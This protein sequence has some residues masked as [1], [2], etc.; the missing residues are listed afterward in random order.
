MIN[1]K[2][3]TF[4]PMQLTVKPKHTFKLKMEGR[5]LI[6]QK[7]MEENNK[8]LPKEDDKGK[9]E[10]EKE[11]EEENW[12]EKEDKEE[13]VVLINR[14]ELEKDREKTEEKE[15]IPKERKGNREDRRSISKVKTVNLEVINVINSA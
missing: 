6:F 12:L 1:D 4:D 10:V 14:E 3:N 11:L 8:I 13:K 15:N 9:E 7:V 2:L 5:K